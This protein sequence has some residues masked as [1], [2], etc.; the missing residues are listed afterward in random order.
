MRSLSQTARPGSL[1]FHNGERGG[2]GR[3]NMAGIPLQT[4][5]GF[6]PTAPG[7]SESS[8]GRGEGRRSI[9]GLRRAGACTPAAV[10]DLAAGTVPGLCGPVVENETAAC[11]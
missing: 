1:C 11:N 6:A 2:I 8:I 5:P 3:L 7:S 10:N 4:S 9:S